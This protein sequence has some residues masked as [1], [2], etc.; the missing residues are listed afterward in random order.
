MRSIIEG[1]ISIFD[2]FFVTPKKPTWK[3]PVKFKDIGRGSPFYWSND[4][5]YIPPENDYIWTSKPKRK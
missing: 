5:T 3:E 2:S 1:I 4:P